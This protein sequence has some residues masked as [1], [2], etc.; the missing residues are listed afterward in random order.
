MVKL[1]NPCRALAGAT[2]E[3]LTASTIGINFISN[4]LKTV[5]SHYREPEPRIAVWQFLALLQ[6]AAMMRLLVELMEVQ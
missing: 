1:E 2:D 5:K 4:L 3:K 6:F